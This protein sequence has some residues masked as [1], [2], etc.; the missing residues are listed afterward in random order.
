MVIMMD[1][2]NGPGC[3]CAHVDLTTNSL[4]KSTNNGYVVLILVLR[5]SWYYYY[6]YY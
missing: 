3:D 4:I 5:I 2:N 1:N 6:Y